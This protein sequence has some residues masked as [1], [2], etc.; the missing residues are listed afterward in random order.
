MAFHGVWPVYG[1]GFIQIGTKLFYMPVMFLTVC[2]LYD[3]MDS[4]FDKSLGSHARLQYIELKMMKE[5]MM[6]G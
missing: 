2:D 3:A 1:P 6:I 5:S 4:S